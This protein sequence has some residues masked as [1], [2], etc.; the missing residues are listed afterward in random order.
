MLMVLLMLR[1]CPHNSTFQSLGRGGHGSG[2]VVSNAVIQQPR[3]YDSQCSRNRAKLRSVVRSALLMHAT[4]SPRPKSPW[5][6]L[7]IRHIKILDPDFNQEH[8]PCGSLVP[9]LRN[10]SSHHEQALEAWSSNT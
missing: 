9:E 7:S 4:I 10:L 6:S 2:R 8:H 3:G 5:G 1:Y